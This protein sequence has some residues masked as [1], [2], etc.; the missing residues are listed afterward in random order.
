MCLGPNVPNE[1]RGAEEKE[2]HPIYVQNCVTRYHSCSDSEMGYLKDWDFF[3]N[4][5]RKKKTDRSN[6]KIKILQNKLFD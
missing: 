4:K 1:K 5:L 3:T 6:G 2:K